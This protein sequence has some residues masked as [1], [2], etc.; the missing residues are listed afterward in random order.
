MIKLVLT[1]L[2]A[3]LIPAQDRGVATAA[4]CEAIA[5]VIGAGVHFGPVTGRTPAVTGFAFPAFPEAYGTGAF[6][7]G[8]VICL[9]NQVIH[10]A[11]CEVG[12]LQRVADILDEL[13]EG[14]VTL[15]DLEGDRG[16]WYVSREPG[17]LG[18]SSDYGV[19]IRE[20]AD[21]VDAPVLKANVRLEASREHL[22]EV[23]DMLRE[24]VPELDFV[25]PAADAP[26]IDITPAGV[27]KGSAVGILAAALGLSLDEVAV[28]GDSENDLS[29]LEAV[30]NSVAV[31][32]ATP[33]VAETARWHIGSAF[34]HA[35]DDAL[36]EIA[37][38]A[39]E[40]RMPAFM[41]A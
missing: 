18:A 3:T 41:T 12:P 28:F 5:A 15:Y 10:R 38:A 7:N 32:N 1:D 29:M 24:S 33:E 36:L 27:G 25:F 37:A 8:Q 17:R 2:D 31:A 20:V 40:G 6:A 21:H 4:T 30:P 9:D 34:D 23:R 11:W 19:D 39:R 16:A 22:T 13:H 26:L 35:M 14:A